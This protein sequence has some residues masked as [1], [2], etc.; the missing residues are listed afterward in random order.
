MFNQLADRLKGTFDK[1]SGRGTL[2]EADVEKALR[3]VRVAL[4]EA[5]VAL[6]VIKKFMAHVR[7]QAVGEDVL[8]SIKPGEQVVKI[9]HDSLLEVLGEGEDLNL[10]TQ[11]PAV[12]LMAG[13][14]GSGKT[15]TAGKLAYRLV[16]KQNKKVL[17]ASTD[18]YRPAAQ[19]Q[20][21]TLASKV[22]CDFMP[23]E[24]G[25]KPVSITERALR[26]ARTEGFD[27]L[28]VDTAGRLELDD[29]LMHELIAVRNTCKPVETLLVTDSLIG[30]AAANVAKAFHEAVG[31]SGIVLTRVDG[32]GRGGAALSMREVTGQ[33]IKFIGL[34]EGID[35]L[36]PFHPQSIAD[37]IL[38]MGDVVSLV[39]KAQAAMEGDDAKELEEKL[40]SGK[41]FD[42]NDLKKQMKMMR[43]MG[44]MKGMLDMLPGMGKLKSKV[45][46]SKLD[47]KVIIHQMAIIDSMT[48]GERKNPDILNAR[49]RQR[50]AKGAGVEVSAVNKLIKMHQQ[51]GKAMKMMHKM[52]GPAAM[53]NMMK[54][55][56]PGGF[57][58]A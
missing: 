3:E 16:N 52:G 38:G 24:N 58:K 36:Q 43:R 25:E 29:E 44:S 57:P 15:T 19:E 8:K 4:L 9:V 27:V 13:L 46:P 31:V 1:L 5:D 30:Q 48:P 40:M 22:G 47:D 12:I 55:G 20:L 34:G 41:S 14:Q 51:M 56:G 10:N 2:S 49:R 11:P 21:Q 53:M 28:I 45:D 6:P 35:A 18:I 23:I 50:I 33:P 17:L 42:L 7:E 37:R 39:E 26:K 32:D 54:Q